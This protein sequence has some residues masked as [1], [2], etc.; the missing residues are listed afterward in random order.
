ML[1]LVIIYFSVSI[2]N[3]TGNMLRLYFWAYYPLILLI[4]NIKIS[5]H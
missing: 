5:K 1:R 4:Q 2:I 3:Y